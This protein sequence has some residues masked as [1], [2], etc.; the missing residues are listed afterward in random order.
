MVDEVDMPSVRE[1][2]LPYAFQVKNDVIVNGRWLLCFITCRCWCLFFLLLLSFLA[3]NTGSDSFF[4]SM[5]M[6]ATATKAELA[7]ALLT[8]PPVPKDV[9]STTRTVHVQQKSL[10]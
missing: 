4:H 8:H 6:V 9:L 1:V 5:T 3:T 7:T 2:I 10:Q